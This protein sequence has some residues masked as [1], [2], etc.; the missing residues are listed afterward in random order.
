MISKT[1]TINTYSP[2]LYYGWLGNNIGSISSNLKWFSL[3]Y[4]S[5]YAN[6]PELSKS[7]GGSFFE[8]VEDAVEKDDILYVIDNKKLRIFR[9]IKINMSN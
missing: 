8:N 4:N 9:N 1:K 2:T 5:I 6:S 3:S 7:S